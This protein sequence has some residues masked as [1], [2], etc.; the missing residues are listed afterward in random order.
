MNYLMHYLLSGDDEDT[1]IGNY[2]AD[3]IRGASVINA[4]PNSI[5]KGILLHR[6]IDR[7]SDMHPAVKNSVS[8]L[9]PFLYHYA[10]VSV[11]IL[12]DHFLVRHWLE[13]SKKPLEQSIAEFYALLENRMDTLPIKSQKISRKLIDNNWIDMYESFEGLEKIFIGMSKRASFKSNMEYT[14]KYLKQYYSE[15]DR[16]F[17]IFANDMFRFI[18]LHKRYEN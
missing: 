5:K 1:I 11:D 17:L 7:Y 4:M 8:L 2:I 18:K 6:V 15:L 3:H 9:Q 12:Y 16:D 10:T 14:V 13:Y